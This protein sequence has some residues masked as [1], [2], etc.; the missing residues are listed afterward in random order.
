APT[1]ACCAALTTSHTQLSA[2]LSG[3][4]PSSTRHA[5]GCGAL[6]GTE[7]PRPRSAAMQ[8]V[9]AACRSKTTAISA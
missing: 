3:P 5:A 6:D 2:S 7:R 8:R 1:R 4:F 9:V